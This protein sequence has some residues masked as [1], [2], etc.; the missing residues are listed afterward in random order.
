MVTY[1]RL[2]D[3]RLFAMCSTDAAGQW[4]H[5]FGMLGNTNG[6]RHGFCLTAAL[7]VVPFSPSMARSHLPPHPASA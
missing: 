3:E 2:T 4:I 1:V 7:A 5:T 6:H